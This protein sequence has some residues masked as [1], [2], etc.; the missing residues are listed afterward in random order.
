MLRWLEY[1]AEK[2][3]NGW[4]LVGNSLWRKPIAVGEREKTN[5]L[6]PIP[7]SASP[8]HTFSLVDR[9][10]MLLYVSRLRVSAVSHLLLEPL[11]SKEITYPN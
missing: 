5:E 4:M 1:S 3:K 6:L 10:L 9:C 2:M 8:R 11:C 7:H